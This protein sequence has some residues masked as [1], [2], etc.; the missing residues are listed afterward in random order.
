M[1]ASM[2]GFEASHHS[3]LTWGN[4]QTAWNRLGIKNQFRPRLM[5]GTLYET[6]RPR[7]LAN[8]AQQ[9]TIF[10]WGPSRTPSR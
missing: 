6:M 7:T 9:T 5:G 3:R 1:A 4:F 10:A 8:G 2:R